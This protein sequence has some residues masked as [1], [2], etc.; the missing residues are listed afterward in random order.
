[1]KIDIGGVGWDGDEANNM[2]DKY[3]CQLVEITDY[4]F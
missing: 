3:I 2:L 1:M 4:L